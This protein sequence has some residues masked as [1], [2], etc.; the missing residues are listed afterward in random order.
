VL[1]GL[2]ICLFVIFYIFTSVHLYI[3]TSVYLYISQYIC[4]S[5]LLG[6]YI[7]YGGH[8]P[9]Q[10]SWLPVQTLVMVVTSAQYLQDDLGHL[11]NE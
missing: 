4:V 11:M 5:V 10:P 1:L 9:L 6:L 2:Y 3:F 8:T 7:L